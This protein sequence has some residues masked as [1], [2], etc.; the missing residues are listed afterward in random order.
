MI[1][2]DDSARTIES[3]QALTM[4][5]FPSADGDNSTFE[6]VVPDRAVDAMEPN[7]DVGCF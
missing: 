2:A 3:A 5:M 4:G 1:R 7:A 6:I